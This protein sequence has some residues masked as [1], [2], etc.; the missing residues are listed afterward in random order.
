MRYLP[1]VPA[2]SGPAAASARGRRWLAAAVAVPTAV[3]TVMLATPAAGEPEPSEPATTTAAAAS[4]PPEYEIEGGWIDP[5]ESVGRGEPVVSEWRVNVNDS[6]DPPGNDPVD[7]VTATFALGNAFFEALPDLCLTEGVEPVSRISEDGTELRCNLGTVRMGTAVVVQIPVVPSGETGEE[8]THVGSIG[9][10]RAE[11]PPIPILND[12]RMDMYYGQNTNFFVWDDIADPTQVAAD[13]QWTLRLGRG[14]DPG[15]PD[16]TYQLT[17][18]AADG[19]P[20]SVGVNPRD[21][22]Q[23]GCT[24][25][26]FN[27]ADGHPWSGRPG[28]PE[29]NTSFVDSCTLTRTGPETFELTLTGI[30]YD[31]LDVPELDSVGN[32]LPPNWAAIASGTLWFDVAT[33][34]RGSLSVTASSP[35]YEAPTGQRFTDLAGNN[36]T[37][38]SYY[39]PG[40]WAASWNRAFTG[41]GG[42]YWDDTYRVPAGTVVQQRTSNRGGGGGS[43]EPTAVWGNCT[44]LDT[45]YVTYQSGGADLQGWDPADGTVVTV[46]PGDPGYDF[47]WYVGPQPADPDRFDC[48]ADPGNWVTTEPADPTT[49]QAVRVT[50]PYAR[51]S[52]TGTERFVLQVHPII[53]P[54]VPHGQDVWMFGSALKGEDWLGPDAGNV[55]TR[56]PD[57]R[58]P[59]TNGRRDILR[60]VSAIPDIRK[61]AASATV[62]PGVPADFTLTYSATG[63]ALIPPTMDGY[64]IVDT[65]PAGM[66]YVA[67]SADP[68]PEVSTDPGGHQVLTWQ[69]DGVE[70]NT[71]H[72]LTYQAV[73]DATVAPGTALTNVAVSRVGDGTPGSGPTGDYSDPARATVTSTTNG[74]TTILK[75]SDVAY[76]PNDEGDGVGTGSWTVAIESFDPMT[77][78]FTDTIDILPYNGDLRGTSYSGTYRL[79]D[80]VL[81]DGGTVYYTDA[82]PATLTDDPADPA[83]GAAGDPTGNTVGWTTIAPDDPTAIRVIGG[84]LEPGAEFSFQL[85]IRTRGAEPEDV[86]WNSAQARAEHTELVMRTSAPLFVTA[87][88]VVKSSKPA[89]GSEVEPGDVVEYTIEVTQVGEVPAGAWLTDDLSQVL[90]DAE[91]NDDVDADLGVASVSG[92]TLSW[93]GEIPVGGTARI[94]YSV[95]VGDRIGDLRVR[96]V[97]TSPGCRTQS[98]CTTDQ[99]VEPLP[100]P[101]PE[102]EGAL[103]GTGGPALLSLALGLLLLAAGAGVIAL[104]RRS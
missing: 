90:D 57:A 28:R 103:P 26:S 14:S 45:A 84:E 18:T 52:E 4:G 76:I 35:T 9:E 36:E 104:R 88:D 55:V 1:F 59:Y 21:P 96:N 51:Y 94:T 63:S 91:Y 43:T 39:L 32:T 7:D 16:V 25:F 56:T 12:F 41:S 95:T 33:S 17:V 85:A 75:T 71:E 11:L 82:D 54:D 92:D 83:N 24:P 65:L 97:V 79:T 46:E 15:P 30:D 38:K 86:F 72:E 80:V 60:V 8:V 47:S 48:G 87:Y 23:V 100:S 10:E 27:W 5:P 2:R 67:G 22:S 73:A 64:E 58:Y 69:F 98:D 102:R 53:D 62:T 99:H 78:G 101:E 74:Y 49:V 6:E 61:E 37:N 50:Y 68:E 42:T 44:V 70:T 20:V 77:Q 31:L 66:T 29:R 81:P 19:S 13:I 93:E 40:S 89:P 3:A 34:S